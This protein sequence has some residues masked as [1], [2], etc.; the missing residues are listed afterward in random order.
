MHELMATYI[1]R[2][3]HLRHTSYPTTDDSLPGGLH[4]YGLDPQT[5]TLVDKTLFN[6]ALAGPAGAM[7]S[8]VADLTRFVRVLCVGGLLTP[9]TQAERMQGQPLQ[10]TATEYGEGVI[11]GPKVC[12][13]SGTIP[14]F[15]TD[16]YYFPDIDATVVINVARLD[17][18]DHSRSSPVL[19]A[20][21]DALIERLG[22]F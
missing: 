14:G 4:G 9:E 2:R 1:I 17:R 20:A 5:G 22:K 3:L 19:K 6:P 15:S 18:D 10:G 12:G 8:T 21:T 7:I 13:H 16:M 11:T